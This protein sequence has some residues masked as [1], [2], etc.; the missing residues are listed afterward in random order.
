MASPPAVDLDVVRRDQAQAHAAYAALAAAGMAVV[1]VILG[2]ALW[3]LLPPTTV[4]PW[5]AS[6]VAPFAGR[7]LLAV[8]HR[9]HPQRMH[10]RTWVA[11]FRLTFVL[12]GLAWAAACFVIL[13]GIDAPERAVLAVAVAGV[14]ASALNTSAFDLVA[15]LSVLAI[16]VAPWIV[17]LLVDGGRLNTTLG[18]MLALFLVYMTVNGTRIHARYLEAL[19]LRHAAA[20]RSNALAT[21]QAAVGRLWQVE[22]ADAG[23]V[24]EAVL[25]ELVA[26]LGLLRVRLF[27]FDH[28]AGVARLTAS[29]GTGTLAA[30]AAPTSLASL[31]PYVSALASEGRLSSEGQV[32]GAVDPAG[33][34]NPLAFAQG[35]ARFDVPLGHAGRVRGVLCCERVVGPWSADE[36]AFLTAAAAMLQAVADDHR[37]R[38]AEQRLVDLN[39]TLEQLVETRTGDLRASEAR[40]ARTL[41]A[42]NDGLW[43]VD[44]ATGDVYYS[45]VWTRLLGYAPAEVPARVEFYW[46]LVHPD[47][48]E[49]VQTTL[50]AHLRGE[51]P[52]KELEVRLRT[53]DG[54]YRWF[55][56]RGTIVERTADGTPRRMLGTISDI[57]AR[58]RMLEDL[59]DSETRFR[60][61][62]DKSPVIVALVDMAESRIAEM[63]AVGLRTFG[64]QRDEMVGRTTLELNLWDDEPARRAAARRL[65]ADG[66]VPGVELQMRRKGGEAFWALLSSSLVTFQGQPYAL[67]T[68]QDITERRRLEARVLQS[69]KLDVVGH[70]A[71]GVAHDFNN[72]LTVITASAE[73]A[74]SDTR[75][76][77]SAHEA[78]ATI[79]AASTRAARLTGQLL[80]FARQQILQPSPI[81]LNA[82]VTDLTP[83]VRRVVGDQIVLDVRFAVAPTTVLADRG[84]LEQVVLNL[85]LN[86]RDAMPDGGRL[87]IAVTDTTRAASSG[88]T[89]APGGY[90]TLTVVDTGTGMSEATQQ[91]IFEPF[92]TTKAP[93]Q[94]TGLGLSM[95]LGVVQQSGGDIVVTSAPGHGS[96]FAVHLPRTSS[97]AAPATTA[98]Q[99]VASG[100]ETVL[101]VDDDPEIRAV[102]GRA[103][104]FAG[105]EVRLAADGDD[106]LETLDTAGPVDL[107]LTDVMM[108]GLGGHELAARVRARYRTTRILFTSG[109]AENA[110]AR[111][112]VLA[113]G[114]QF[115]AK[116][117]S[118]RD[119]ATKVREVL[120]EPSGPPAS[121]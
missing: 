67:A 120:D 95:A 79:H 103:L 4:V 62:F 93:G 78:L 56:D 55:H 50:E 53:R 63:N 57:T 106:A 85:A 46:Q 66:L 19:S 12:H 41:D 25:R 84:S 64:Y 113:A 45:P 89:L 42:T 33:A 28:D 54:E 75:S 61:L 86:A 10:P 119:L 118:L 92:F 59:H 116:P 96:S 11:A 30:D 98:R 18:S 105:Y 6:L 27:E 22:Q 26:A 107:L 114:V 8:D 5:L 21:L 73:L 24:R 109:Y 65:I 80:A 23:V 9:H 102:I 74:L 44:L 71:G 94:G 82:V 112:G 72:V 87:I 37:R 14:T 100:T 43:D 90:G 15:G 16:S 69:Q 101:V 108:P 104:T 32:A 99:A 29:S 58:R 121:G 34:G 48:V 52:V 38:I 110:I 47:D 36:A 39:Q 83:M 111:K 97:E 91:R 76:G 81:D 60:E 1:V 2:A 20:A 51:T 7:L 35:R 117:Y 40:L 13:P 77:D 31:A 88:G 68:L 17:R 49:R 115:I 3:P 70:L